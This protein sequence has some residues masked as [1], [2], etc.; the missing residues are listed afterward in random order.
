M[1][2]VNI[3]KVKKALRGNKDTFI[4]LIE[5]RKK[6]IY[7]LAYIYVGNEDDSLDLVQDIVYK[8]YISINKLK[9]PEYF[10]TWITR[11]T[12]NSCINFLKKK[13]RILKNELQGLEPEQ[14]YKYN[15]NAENIKDTFG[16]IE[17]NID[18]KKAIGKLDLNLKTIIILKYYQDLTITQISELISAPSG[19]V[20]THLNKALGILRLELKGGNEKW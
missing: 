13:R 15:E 14:I 16:I 1:V 6:D 19:T 8:A 17:S 12:I 18:L 11:I 4:E 20:K 3:K 2:S 7:R 10:N 5:E 9:N